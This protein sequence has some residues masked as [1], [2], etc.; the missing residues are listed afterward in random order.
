MVGICTFKP[1]SFHL[2]AQVLEYPEEMP[3]IGF[4]LG[5]K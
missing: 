2:K 4:F 1:L 5:W 3:D